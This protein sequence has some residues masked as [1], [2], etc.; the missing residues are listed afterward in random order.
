MSKQSLVVGGAAVVIFVEAKCSLRSRRMKNCA[1]ARDR[2]C[3]EA[4]CFSTLARDLHRQDA[5]V[6]LLASQKLCA[7][8]WLVVLKVIACQVVISPLPSVPLL[9]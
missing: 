2:T 1:S 4:F 9:R 8:S 5:L 3:N 6:G 7:F